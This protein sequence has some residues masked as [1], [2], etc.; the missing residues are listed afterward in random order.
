LNDYQCHTERKII[1][2]LHFSLRASSSRSRT[3]DIPAGRV[4]KFPLG[5]A[6]HVIA[7]MP[8]ELFQVAPALQVYWK[9]ADG[10]ASKTTIIPGKGIQTFQTA[11]E[12][13]LEAIGEPN[14]QVE[15]GYVLLG[16]RK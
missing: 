15:Y 5:S 11:G 7:Q 6:D 16:L 3:D 9:S 1:T 8:S 14:R 10:N 4:L 12:F 2:A 13:R